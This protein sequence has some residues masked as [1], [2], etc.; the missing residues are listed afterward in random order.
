MRQF[1][2]PQDYTF[3]LNDEAREVTITCET[4]DEAIAY[5]PQNASYELCRVNGDTRF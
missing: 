2:Y 3:F 1:A 5:L 4:L